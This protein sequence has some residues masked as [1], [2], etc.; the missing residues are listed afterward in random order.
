MNLSKENF[1]EIII[2][3]K[4]EISR[5]KIINKIIILIKLL[6]KGIFLL[7]KLLKPH[8]IEFKKLNL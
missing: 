4:I 8:S 5:S 6:D 2:G 1:K 3:I 7:F